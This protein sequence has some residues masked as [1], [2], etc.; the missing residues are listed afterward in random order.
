MVFTNGTASRPEHVAM[1]IGDGWV[2]HAPRPGRVVEGAGL[3]T[4]G[5]IL[6]TRQITR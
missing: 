6:V 3:A 1:F 4:H 2:V 5:T